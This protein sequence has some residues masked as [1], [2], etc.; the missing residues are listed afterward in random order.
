MKHEKTTGFA[1]PAQG[2][3]DTVIDLNALLVKRPAATFFFRLENG[4]MGDLG[5]QKGVLL[6]V[7]SICVNLRIFTTEYCRSENSLE[8]HGAQ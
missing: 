2:Y 8:F 4:D 7:D 1:S 5:L 3:E 6:V